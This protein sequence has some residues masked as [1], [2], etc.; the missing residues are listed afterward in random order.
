MPGVIIYLAAARSPG[1]GRVSVRHGVDDRAEERAD[2]AALMTAIA[3]RADRA[4]FARL[5]QTYAPKVKA[6]LVARGAPAGVADELVQDVMLVVWRK[7]ALFD[8]ARGSLATWLYTISRNCLLNH[9]RH[10]RRLDVDDDQAE[11][12]VGAGDS[13]DAM[14]ASA[15]RRK[16]AATLA[17]LPVE[18]LEVL[19]RAYWR[20]QTMQECADAQGIPLGTVKTRVRLALGRLRELMQTGQPIQ[21]GSDE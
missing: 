21:D 19:H 9:V 14:L 12:A 13:E 3:E 6:H 8:A 7:A 1:G 5:F 10:D 11:P 17:K 18:Q 2:D 20:G 15:S 4:A 16:L